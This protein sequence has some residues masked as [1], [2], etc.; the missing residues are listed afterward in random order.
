VF[1]GADV[2]YE[3]SSTFFVQTPFGLTTDGQ[4]LYVTDWDKKAIFEVDVSRPTAAVPEVIG[5]VGLPMS[6]EYSAVSGI[7][8]CP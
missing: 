8:Y 3:L 6:V 7:I 4:K 1:I 5:D 2:G